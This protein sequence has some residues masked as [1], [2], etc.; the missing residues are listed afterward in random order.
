MQEFVIGVVGDD[1]ALSGQHMANIRN[2]WKQQRA[3]R[4][5][6]LRQ[7]NQEV[8]SRRFS[9]NED[10]IQVRACVRARVLIVSTY[11][12]ACACFLAHTTR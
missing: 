3:L 4:E 6:Q 1:T 10:P 8:V 2:D 5:A 11:P 7:R 12:M 9:Q